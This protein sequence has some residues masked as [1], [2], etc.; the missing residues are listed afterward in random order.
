L[1]ID[2]DFLE[3]GIRYDATFYEDGPDASYIDNKES[4]RVRKT[5]VK[6]GDVVSVT[7]AA[8]GGNSIW[9]RRR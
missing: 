3:D 5:E 8:G 9:I 7:L 1:S 2:L 4:C 6:K